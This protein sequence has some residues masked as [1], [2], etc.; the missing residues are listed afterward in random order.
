MG[1][2]ELHLSDTGRGD[3]MSSKQIKPPVYIVYEGIYCDEWT[4]EWHGCMY[5]NEEDVL[6]CNLFLCELHRKKDK[7]LRCNECLKYTQEIKK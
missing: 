4:P 7:I 1:W 2:R 6:W 3:R 5:Q